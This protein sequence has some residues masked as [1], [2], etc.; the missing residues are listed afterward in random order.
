MLHQLENPW[1]KKMEFIASEGKYVFVVIWLSC[2]V[3]IIFEVVFKS[4]HD[5]VMWYII[6]TRRYN[7]SQIV[8]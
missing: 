4:I 2:D 1:E 7:G 3:E 8:T 5:H 6:L